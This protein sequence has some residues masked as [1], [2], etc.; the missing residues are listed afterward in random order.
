M[1]KRAAADHHKP[2]ENSHSR[3][4]FP[5]PW[6][7]RGRRKIRKRDQR[8]SQTNSKLAIP[9]CF[10]CAMG[11]RGGRKIRKRRQQPSQTNSKLAIPNCFFS[12]MGRRDGRKIRKRR[13]KRIYP[14][15]SHQIDDA[16]PKAQRTRPLRPK[17]S[18]RNTVCRSNFSTIMTVCHPFFLKFDQRRTPE[19]VTITKRKPEGGRKTYVL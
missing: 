4:V 17:F 16:V 15:G 13:Q 10:S 7:R 1:R 9:P 3:S 11:R 12:A 19:P 18:T 6:G 8:P 14:L 5:S 2:T